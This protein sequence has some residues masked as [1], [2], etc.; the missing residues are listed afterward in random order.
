M[1]A[2]GDFTIISSVTRRGV[3]ARAAVASNMAASTPMASEYLMTSSLCGISSRSPPQSENTA[4]RSS[5]PDP[6]LAQD[7]RLE[8]EP[9]AGPLRR[10]DHAVDDRQRI[11]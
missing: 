10:R 4:E 6:E 8:R 7:L 1:P 3:C 11:D 5:I 9:V 2:S